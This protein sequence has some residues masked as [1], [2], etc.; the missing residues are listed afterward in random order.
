MDFADIK[1]EPVQSP[2]LPRLDSSSPVSDF[3][4]FPSNHA[5]NG[6]KAKKQKG[7]FDKYKDSSG[8][9]RLEL[10][11]EN[12]YISFIGTAKRMIKTTEPIGPKILPAFHA[13]IVR[14]L[15]EE[16][17]SANQWSVFRL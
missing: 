1:S 11:S 8:K 7:Q 17:V 16:K 9:I 5:R 10:V 15:N 2:G 12:F 6:G 3:F 13:T 14:N 4:N